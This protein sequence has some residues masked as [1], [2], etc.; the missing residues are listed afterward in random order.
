M[1]VT[2][3]V[4][5]EVTDSELHRFARVGLQAV[6]RSPEGSTLWFEPDPDLGGRFVVE[7][8]LRAVGL[9][10]NYLG[11]RSWDAHHQH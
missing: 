5:R 8:C 3:R 11:T 7:E 2:Y 9:P 1:C 4:A 6:A 10:F